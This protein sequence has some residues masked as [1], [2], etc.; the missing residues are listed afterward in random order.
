MGS[1]RV[2]G[3]PIIGITLDVEGEYL[4][5]RQAYPE[6]ILIAGGIP[7]MI[8][9]L[10]DPYLIAETIDGLL[11]PGGGDIDPSYYAEDACSTLN[12]VPKERSDFEINLLRRIMVQRKPIFGIC[13]G[14]QLINVAFG[15]SLYQDLG[16]RFDITVDHGQ[17][18]HRITGT[19]EG[20][21][22]EFMV[23]SSHHQGIKKMGNGLTAAAYSDDT[24]VEATH[25]AGY[26]FLTAVQWHPE[27][28]DD[29]LSRGLLRLFVEQARVSK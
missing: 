18:I 12:L 16:S 21:Q 13:Y 2:N 9:P 14:M 1:E 5:L 3:K 28:S 17:G 6:A 10:N 20:I 24:L 29:A 11:I 19:G 26:P 22:G 7:L 27:R 8:P 25:M 15:G 4:R 23:N